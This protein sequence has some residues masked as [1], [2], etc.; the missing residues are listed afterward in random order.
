MISGKSDIYIY[1][2]KL[3]KLNKKFLNKK[4][5]SFIRFL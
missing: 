3:L 2:I 5:E 1:Y 4:Q